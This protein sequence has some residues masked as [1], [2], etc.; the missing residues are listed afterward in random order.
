MSHPVTQDS[1]RK[2]SPARPDADL[3]CRVID[4][5]GD[6]GVCW[7]LARCL[8]R[9]HGWHV[10]LWVDALDA[11]ARIKPQGAAEPGVEVRQ[12]NDDTL[13]CLP[14][15][16]VI[17][18]F[19]CDL[20]PALVMSMAAQHPPP[21]WINLEYLS[22]EAWVE[23]CH[24]LPSYDAA[25]GLTKHFFFPGFTARTGG[26]LRE[27]DLPAQ[28]DAWLADAAARKHDLARL[29]M[30]V[31]T[32]ALQ[33][34]LFGYE[35]PSIAT[36]IEALAAH[37]QPVQLWV[38]EGRSLTVAAEALGRPLRAGEV[39][40][41]GA[42][43]LHALAF[44]DQDDFDRLLWQCDLNIVRGEDSFV[45]AQWAARPML[46]HIYP[47]D[48]GAHLTKL[49]AFLDRHAEGLPAEVA[50]RLRALH[51]GWNSTAAVPVDDWHAVLGDLPL[52]AS[53][54]RQR[55]ASLASHDDLATQLV[56]FNQPPI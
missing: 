48:G 33:L 22:A 1:S 37:A 5:F 4:N 41:R 18:A 53:H 29:G 24:G 46:W 27:R 44:M 17:E 54:A 47:Q 40:Q 38:P 56:M 39:V 10:R 16:C 32:G 42:L 19:A 55:A 34:S 49:D 45:R 52:L 30:A 51:R 50:T 6:I 11:L 43:A 31:D 28:R 21:R 25:S 3:F 35:S 8:A 15:R 36:L 26:L 14:A 23:G 9:D 2:L 20:P 7:R 13:S 12:L